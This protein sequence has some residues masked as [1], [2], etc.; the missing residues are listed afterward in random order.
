MTNV[1]KRLGVPPGRYRCRAR[2]GL[3][4]D[5]RYPT[6]ARCV[7]R[8]GAS[9]TASARSSVASS[10]PLASTCTPLFTPS[11]VFKPAPTSGL[12]APATTVTLSRSDIHQSIPRPRALHEDRPAARPAHPCSAGSPPDPS[13]GCQLLLRP[14]ISPSENI[15]RAS[16]KTYQ[17]GR[18]TTFAISAVLIPGL[19]SINSRTRRQLPCR[20]GAPTPSVSASGDAPSTSQSINRTRRLGATCPHSRH[21]I[22]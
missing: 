14:R 18:S 21:E 13:A 6:R 9:V 8:R 3:A 10:M 1:G 11:S 4:R 19:P 7:R 2:T 22:C 17:N 16:R 20:V 12:N 15:R 5:P